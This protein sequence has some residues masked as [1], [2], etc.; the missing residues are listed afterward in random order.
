MPQELE[1]FTKASQGLVLVVGPTGHGKTTTLAA[2][3]DIINHT[4][5]KH[6][7]TVEDP[8][9]YLFSQ[10]KCIVDQREL[11]QDTNSFPESLRSALR[12]DMDVIMVG[13]MRDLETI[14]MAITVAE[15]GHL[16]FSTLHTN[17]ASETI[18]RVIDVFS[19]HQQNQ[20]R[21][22]LANILLGVVSQRLVPR[23]GGGRVPVAEIMIVNAAIRNLIREN[24]THQINTVIQTSAERGMVPL[25]KSLAEFV[26]TGEILMSDA[27]LY[28]NDKEGL[29]SLVRN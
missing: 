6:I 10:D 7:I 1:E 28:A 23:I 2:L 11:Y 13:E 15:T 22:Q 3:V 17:N 29:Q 5:N 24:K 26:K 8:I 21:V 18:D 14:A 9:E 20:I 19:S 16:V 25:D 27:L 12:E 4:Y